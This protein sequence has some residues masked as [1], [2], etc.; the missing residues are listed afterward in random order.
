MYWCSTIHY[1][2]QKVLQMFV[3]HLFPSPDL[4]VSAEDRPCYGN[5][6]VVSTLVMMYIYVLYTLGFS[7]VAVARFVF[8]FRQSLAR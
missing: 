5:S 8:R 1:H 2:I 6:R 7:V 4:L 3:M